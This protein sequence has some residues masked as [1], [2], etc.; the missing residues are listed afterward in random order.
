MQEIRAVFDK[1]ANN[2]PALARTT[3]VHRAARIEALMKALMARKADCFE[4]GRIELG[5]SPGDVL[6]QFAIIKVEADFAVKSLAKWMQ[7]QHVPNSMMTMAK[8]I[9]IQYEPKGVVLNLSTWNAPLAIGLVPAIAAIA[10]GNAVLLKPS[11]LAPQSAVLLAEIVAAAVPDDEFAVVQGGPEAAEALLA[12]PFNHIYYT[13]GQRVG[14]IVMRAAAE[15]F[16]GVTLEMGGK[17]PVFIDDSADLHDAARKIAWG[18]LSNAGQVCVAPDY[19]LV[20][21]GVHDRFVGELTAE[22]PKMYNADGRGFEHSPDFPRLVNQGHWARVQGLID[23]AVAK[24]AHVA[25]GGPADAAT[26]FI[27]PTVL[28]N[29]SG[30]MR[31]MQEEI[32][33]PVLPVLAYDDLNEAMARVRRG[34]KPLALYIY[35]TDRAVMDAVLSG[36]SAGSTVINHNM[37]QSG[38]NPNLPFGGANGSGIG[39]VGGHRGFL[40]FSNARSVV[41]ETRAAAPLTPL[42]PFNAKTRKMMED[43]LG[44]STILPPPMI[45]AIEAVLKL[46]AMF[47]KG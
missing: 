33:G 7:P 31:V 8:K 22:I 20:K 27:P 32:F 5:L 16:A 13:G 47:V 42:P 2:A 23:D 30:D 34:S 17:N 9:W 43:M 40:E 11:E 39:R 29:V 26:R 18:R 14:R 46:R 28:T 19:A 10:A 37:V 41:E 36:T 6:G 12:L 35:A 44:R 21:R 4:A 38:T 45:A 25:L 1:L 15:Y 24:G 3:A